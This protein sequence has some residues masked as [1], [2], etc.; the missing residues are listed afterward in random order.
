MFG[1]FANCHSSDIPFTGKTS[2]SGSGHLK[3][4]SKR[5]AKLKLKIFRGVISCLYD[6]NILSYNMYVII[7]ML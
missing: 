6:D 2:V 7:C 5:R 1:C 4:K 3:D